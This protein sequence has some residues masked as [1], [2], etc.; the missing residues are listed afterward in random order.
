[1]AK[2][3][4]EC[5]SAADVRCPFYLSDDR[6]ERSISCEGYSEKSELISR[7]KT[8]DR[9]D[10]HMGLYCVGSFEKCPVYKCTYGAKYA[11]E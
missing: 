11:D 8:V 2:F 3:N 4:K 7:F 9:K 10:R 6:T 1:M 5:W